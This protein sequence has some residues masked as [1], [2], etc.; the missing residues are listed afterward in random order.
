MLHHRKIIAALSVLTCLMID[1]RPSLAQSHF[2]PEGS[3]FSIDFPDPP[4]RKSAEDGGVTLTA[5]ISSRGPTRFSVSEMFFPPDKFPVEPDP[6]DEMQSILDGMIERMKSELLS[7]EKKDFTATNGKKLPEKHF[8]FGNGK[9]WGEGIIVM[10]GRHA[11]LV[12]IVRRGQDK[13]LDPVGH[14]FISSFQISN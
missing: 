3:S 1:L 7:I 11:Y 10:L 14:K 12:V 4:Q 2:A 5:Y 8:T 13:G 9:G 6:V